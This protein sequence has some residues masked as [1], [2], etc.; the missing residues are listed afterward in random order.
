[1]KRTASLLLSSAILA[2][3]AAAA[4]QPA[5]EP[6]IFGLRVHVPEVPAAVEFYTAAL[7]FERAGFA[8]QD[9]TLLG[10]GD[11]HLWLSRGS[12]EAAKPAEAHTNLNLRV[13]NLEAACAAVVD[14]GGSVEGTQDFPLG[15][16][17]EARDPFG[18][19][20]HLLHVTVGDEPMTGEIDVFNVGLSSTSYEEL[21][22]YLELL[23]FEV[24]SRDYLPTALPY[25][26]TGATSLVAHAGAT[27][28]AVEGRR[29]NVVLLE[30]VDL[31][32]ARGAIEA[33]GLEPGATRPTPFGR[34]ASLR[35]PAGLEL[36]LI[37]RSPAQLG[38]ERFRALD[39]TWRGESTAGWTANTRFEVIA[40]GTVVVQTSRHDAH[41]D[42]TMVT[43]YHRDGARLVLTHYC[44]AGNQ[45]RLAAASL[46]DDAI[47]LTFDGATNL[48]SRDEGH[49]DSV[50][51]T[52]PGLDRFTSRWS[53][54]QAGENRWMEE[55]AYERVV[56]AR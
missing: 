25:R 55:I 50:R 46:T 38:F 14:A 44:V 20:L 41:P 6:R 29:R 30:T 26:P 12:G 35:T 23:D 10:L 56:A 11:F 5:F 37:E 51:F 2:P 24:H 43:A 32:A 28:P 9:A 53:W 45:P 17:A 48:A 54:Y 16:F 42:E 34:V 49:M 39:G 19:L 4:Q 40:R 47:E 33:H 13:A 1:M 8:G 27:R 36:Q 7:G 52:F 3:A 15:R 21:E 18:N 22:P 31:D